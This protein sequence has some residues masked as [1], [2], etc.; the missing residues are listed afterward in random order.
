MRSWMSIAAATAARAESNSTSM[1][2]P[3]LWT[4]A[5]PALSMAGRQTSLRTNRR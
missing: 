5:P 4:T 3:L 1:E 2:S